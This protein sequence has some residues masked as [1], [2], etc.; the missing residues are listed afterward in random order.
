MKIVFIEKELSF[1]YISL[2]I[3]DNKGYISICFGKTCF[4]LTCHQTDKIRLELHHF[5]LSR[6]NVRV[7]S[8]RSIFSSINLE[9]FPWQQ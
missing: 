9:K 7:L 3:N 8:Q 5:F 6:L 2:T 1:H 4:L